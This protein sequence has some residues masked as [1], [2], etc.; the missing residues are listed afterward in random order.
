[1]ASSPRVSWRSSPRWPT[2]TSSPSCATTRNRRSSPGWRS[3]AGRWT[4]PDHPA[5][6]RRGAWR[7][8]ARVGDRR[9]LVHDGR[10]RPARRSRPARD[11]APGDPGSSSSWRAPTTR[12]ATPPGRSGLY[13]GALAGGLRE[14]YRHP[15]ADPGA[16]TLRNLGDRNALRLLDEVE[17]THPGNRCR[18]GVPCPRHLVDAGRSSDAVADLVDSLVDHATDEDAAAYRRPLHAYAAR[19]RSGVP[20]TT[21]GSVGGVSTLPDGRADLDEMAGGHR[22]KPLHG[23]GDARPGRA[24]AVPVY[25]A[26]RYR[27]FYWVSVPDAHHSRNVTD[28]P[29]VRLVVFDSSLRPAETEAVY[30]TATARIVPEDEL[31]DVVD[32]AFGPTAAPCVSP[33][34]TCA[35]RRRCGCTWPRRARTGAR[36][37]SAPHARARL[38]LASVSG[39]HV[40]R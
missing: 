4:T 12:P 16:S 21:S 20:A 30:M 8:R 24:A 23:P 17:V 6:G 2:G 22:R 31:A 40:A 25:T 28:R 36:P 32:E 38:R 1:M 9:A 10:R 37:G 14:P 26:A 33:P 11:K 5:E 15:R 35:V 34:T 27:D 3:T 18:G 19:L 7:A 39:P 29:Q 13:E